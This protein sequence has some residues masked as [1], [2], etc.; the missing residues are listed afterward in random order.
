MAMEMADFSRIG[1]CFMMCR[2]GDLM[3]FVGKE[4]GSVKVTMQRAAA[5]PTPLCSFH[6]RRD[7]FAGHTEH[8]ELLAERL[9]QVCERLIPKSI[10]TPEHIDQ[11]AKALGCM[12]AAIL[13][14]GA[15]AD[16]EEKY[17]E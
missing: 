13:C 11:S 16:I 15:I 5:D 6:V 9:M 2:H 14:A 3:L 4:D 1:A 7:D 8:Q 12:I 17:G 10:C